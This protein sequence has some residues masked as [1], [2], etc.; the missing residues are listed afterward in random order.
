[1][2][3]RPSCVGS[4][5]TAITCACLPSGG[6]ARKA[7]TRS[8]SSSTARP[9]FMPSTRPAGSAKKPSAGPA[10]TMSL[11]CR[12]RRRRTAPASGR[13]GTSFR[14][15]GLAARRASR[16]S[17]ASRRLSEILRSGLALARSPPRRAL[18][19]AMRVRVSAPVR[20]REL[21]DPQHAVGADDHAGGQIDED[22]VV[23][24]LF[25][26]CAE[27]QFGARASSKPVTAP[28]RARR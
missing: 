26:C 15:S 2:R 16:R 19:S 23:V 20:S 1:M 8:C 10:M 27:T 6:K 21:L 5:E 18:A 14:R 22:V 12:D 25:C 17:A 11:G 4:I 3:C 9:E 28:T 7:A 13:R 24:L